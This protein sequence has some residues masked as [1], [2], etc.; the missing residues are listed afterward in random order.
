MNRIQNTFQNA[1]KKDEKILSVFITA[2]YPALDSTAEL[3]WRLQDSGADVIEIGVPFSD[4]I[5]DGPTIQHA[6]KI[7]LDNGMSLSLA[8]EQIDFVRQKSAIPIILMG[9]INPFFKYGLDRFIKD[10]T[11]AGVDGLIIPDLLP[12]ELGILKGLLNSSNFGVNFLVSANTPPSR[13]KKIDKLTSDFIY[14]VSLTGVTGR[15]TGVPS[16]LIDFVQ[17]IRPVVAHPLLVGFGI[18]NPKDAKEIAQ[19]ADGVIVGSAVLDLITE[20][21]G[22]SEMLSAVGDFVQSLKLALKGD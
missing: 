20:S 18:S 3:V 19:N 7:A 12:E 22:P 4:P 15:R 8:L 5:A 13:I 1:Q 11:A 21:D 2:G 17:S 6:S 10:A 9:Y 14:C 16:G